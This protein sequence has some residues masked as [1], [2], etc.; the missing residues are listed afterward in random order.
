MSMSDPLGD[1]L[2]RIRNGQHAAQRV[3]V[4]P[5]SRLRANVLDVLRREGYIRAWREEA[6]E[7][8]HPQLSIELKYESGHPVIRKISRVSRPGRRTYAKINDLPRAC[9]G[10]GIYVVSTPMGVLSD[11]EA[12]AQ[13]VGGEV[14]AEVF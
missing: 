6:G 11:H 9:N 13:N 12:R 14:L 8:G 10:L 4:C 7:R 3:V 2:S 1:M 5:F